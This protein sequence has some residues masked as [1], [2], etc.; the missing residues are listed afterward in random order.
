M[1]AGC[2]CAHVQK[3]IQFEYPCEHGR[4]YIGI[5]A[6][7]SKYVCM[8]MGKSE[9]VREAMNGEGVYACMY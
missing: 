6:G 1:W 3:Q 7:M 5:Y 9:A 2:K 8:G 4:D